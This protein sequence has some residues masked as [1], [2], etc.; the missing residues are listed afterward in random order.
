MKKENITNKERLDIIRK[1]IKA[2]S[3]YLMY[4]NALHKEHLS[5]GLYPL[6]Y[7]YLHPLDPF[8]SLRNNLLLP[9]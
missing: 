1:N 2:F 9:N 8:L 4:S 3:D 7:N 5:V 6:Y